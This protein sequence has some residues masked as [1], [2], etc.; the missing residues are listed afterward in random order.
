AAVSCSG[1]RLGDGVLH[2]RLDRGTAFV[3]DSFAL[4][5]PLGS[6]RADGRWDFGGPLSAHLR[7]DGLQLD[8]LMGTELAK[9]LRARGTLTLTGTVGGTD[10]VPDVALSMAGPQVYLSGR[11]LGAMALEARV[12]GEQV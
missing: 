11:A 1:R 7:V 4:R 10:E 8:E 2:A 6:S 9:K 3:L 12:V 5:G